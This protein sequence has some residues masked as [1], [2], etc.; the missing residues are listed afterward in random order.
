MNK[1]LLTEEMEQ[2]LNMGSVIDGKYYFLP[3]W[4]EKTDEKGIYIEHSLEKLPEKLKKQI[5]NL[6]K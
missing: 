5:I 6:R 2:F 3:F 1:L 4:F